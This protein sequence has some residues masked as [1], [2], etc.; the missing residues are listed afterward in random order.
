MQ[1]STFLSIVVIVLLS[2]LPLISG[3]VFTSVAFFSDAACTVPLNIVTAVNA[4]NSPP[5][6]PSL[7]SPDVGNG[8][9]NDLACVNGIDA[10]AASG[11]YECFVGGSERG[12]GV[13]EYAAPNCSGAPFQLFEFTGLPNQTCLPGM[14]DVLKSSLNSTNAFAMVTC[15]ISSPTNAAAPVHSTTATVAVLLFI[16]LVL[17]TSS[18]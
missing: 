4:T 9:S 10:D 15:S 12:F 8:S 2:L 6:W 18:L 5:V 16:A 7:P 1:Q 3:S 13:S 11:R 17:M 14:I